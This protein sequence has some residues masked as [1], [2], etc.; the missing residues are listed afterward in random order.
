PL[1]YGNANAAFFLVALWPAVALAARH[2]IAS[3]FRGLMA[4][5]AT[6][7]I[8]LAV[9]SQSRGSLIA[10]VVAVIVYVAVSPQR[11]RVI[12]WLVLPGIG[13][14]AAL[15]WLLDPFP[16]GPPPPPLPPPL[17]PPPP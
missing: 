16:P 5:T 14:A 1:G 8:E 10:A 15:P 3:W 6:L 13:A 11:I 2:E 17:P 9:L 4:G 7:C 12:A